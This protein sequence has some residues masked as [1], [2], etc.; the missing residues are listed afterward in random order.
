MSENASG[1]IQIDI[2]VRQEK[3]CSICGKKDRVNVDH[4]IYYYY[5]I[6]SPSVQAK[7]KPDLQ[8]WGVS[9]IWRRKFTQELS[10]LTSFQ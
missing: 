7:N 4:T 2:G 1:P 3:V 6:L 5:P 9:A 10:A 8:K